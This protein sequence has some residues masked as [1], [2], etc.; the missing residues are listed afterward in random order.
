MYKRMFVII[1]I[2]VQTECRSYTK[3][4]NNNPIGLVDASDGDELIIDE[5][6]ND[7]T[8]YDTARLRDNE[9]IRIRR[10]ND[11]D[12]FDDDEGGY[13]LL[14]GKKNDQDFGWNVESCPE[15]KIRA[16]WGKCVT[17]AEYMEKLKKK[18]PGC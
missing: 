14:P 4:E 1:L 17:C 6:K 18:G 13:V 7:D 3:Y 8:G 15:G 2:S 10:Q 9:L 5:L 11:D 16:P 12:E